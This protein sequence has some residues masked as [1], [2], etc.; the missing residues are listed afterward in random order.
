MT[1]LPPQ[2]CSYFN[3]D[4]LKILIVGRFYQDSPP[5]K[6]EVMRYLMKECRGRANPLLVEEVVNEWWDSKYGEK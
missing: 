3:E 6:K 4:E 1:D 5:T 2:M